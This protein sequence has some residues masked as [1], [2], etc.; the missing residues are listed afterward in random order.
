MNREILRL[1]IPNIISNVSVPLLGIV[2]TALVGHME[3]VHFIGG[4]A[5]GTMIFNLIYFGLGFLSMGTSGL[6]AQAWGAGNRNEVSHVFWRSQAFA[7]FMGLMLILLQFPRA[8]VGFY[9][10]EASPEVLYY[11]REYLFIRIW[12]APAT[13][14]LLGIQG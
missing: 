5:V 1:A 13:L 10:V 9:F 6:T 4:L 7:L 3:A 8:W 11:A 2:D 14:S 12:S